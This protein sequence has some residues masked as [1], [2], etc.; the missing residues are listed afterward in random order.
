MPTERGYPLT[1]P[2]A[3]QITGTAALTAGAVAGGRARR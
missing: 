2:A 3:Q 1:V